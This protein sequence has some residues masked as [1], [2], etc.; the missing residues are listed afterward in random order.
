MQ[1]F[2]E[3]VKQND[4]MFGYD[5]IIRKVCESKNP[6]ITEKAV[7]VADFIFD[8]NDWIDTM[9]E[10]CKRVLGAFNY[11]DFCESL[12]LDE[13]TVSILTE[14]FTSARTAK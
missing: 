8:H 7:E 12:N 3:F 6:E 9:E 10:L 13:K 4:F 14:I 2:E 11:S 5:E 1:N